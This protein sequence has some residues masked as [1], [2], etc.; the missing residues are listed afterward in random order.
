MSDYTLT[1]AEFKRLKTK[2]TRAINS[3][4]NAKIIKTCDEAL[5]IFDEKGSPDDWSRWQR[6]KEDAIVRQR[7]E[8]VDAV[9]AR[10]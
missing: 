9:S 8:K 4:D 2:L 1:Q 5:A 7:Y 3:K 6:A 10:K